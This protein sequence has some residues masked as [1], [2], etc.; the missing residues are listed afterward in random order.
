MIQN[1][2]KKVKKV[3]SNK[4]FLFIFTIVFILGLLL[5]VFKARAGLFDDIAN[6][7]NAALNAIEEEVG[8]LMKVMIEIF[9]T[10]CIGLVAVFTSS[11]ILQGLVA[12]TEWLKINTS[13]LVQSGWH[14]TAGLANLVLI[15]I[16]IIIAIGYILRLETLQARKSLIRL[17][18]VALLMNFSLV[19][20]GMLVDIAN[21]LYR[22][23]LEKGGPNFIVNV[24][25]QLT[26]GG[27]VLVIATVAFL[28]AT[29]VLWAIPVTA[30]FAQL[31][32]AIFMLTANLPTVIVWTFQIVIFFFMAGI[33][34]TYIFLFAARVF[35]IQILA[36]VSPLAFICLILPQTRK[37]FNEWLHH[38]L[39]WL[40]LGIMVLL[41]LVI[42]SKITAELSPP[43]LLTFVPVIGFFT[44][45]PTFSFY[46]FILIFL[47]MVLWLSK[48]TMPAMA[49]FIIQQ[50]TNMAGMAWQRVGAP[51][52]RG[53]KEQV[54]KTAAEQKG[55]EA[56]A[57]RR[58]E[59]GETLSR[60]ESFALKAGAVVAA[61]IR[62]TYRLRGTTPEAEMRKD[63]SKQASEFAAR[64]KEDRE[65]LIAYLPKLTPENQIAA[66]LALKELKGDKA[67]SKIP[68]DS[69]AGVIK[70]ASRLHPK[71]LD[72]LLTEVQRERAEKIAERDKSLA[73]ALKNWPEPEDMAAVIKD[74]TI[75]EGKEAS[76]LW[77]GSEADREKV[78]K[79]AR[80]RKA[81][82]N[83]K[84]EDYE[85]IT[86][87]MAAEEEFL[88]GAAR[89]CRSREAV[90]R[91]LE[92]GILD[93]GR[94]STTVQKLGIKE[95]AKTN[96]TVLTFPY[97]PGGHALGLA[98]YSNLRDQ[99]GRTITTDKTATEEIRRLT[100][101]IR[102]VAL[103]HERARDIVRGAPIGIPPSPTPP[104]SGRPGPGPT[105]GRPPRRPAG[106]P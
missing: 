9:L 71:K 103:S 59:R 28:I 56:E 26:G 3:L 61:P 106:R 58:L 19:F 68:D 30:P 15:I 35:V 72:D 25:A 83:L 4:K 76:E 96:T 23:I 78:R 57:K 87:E 86:P 89:Y 20:I 69:F 82:A 92:K 34:L 65:G 1:I 44:L 16:F 45:A 53:F 98:T 24:T 67:L 42:G 85:N 32:F 97:T 73:T 6:W 11:S 75:I 37:Y 31:G 62:W 104:P 43:N 70:S 13:T 22:T 14:F 33:F 93:W 101:E 74:R 81:F 52:T 84:V 7:A 90:R 77:K 21:I 105:P 29:V 5:P 95:V 27:L 60:G 50:A 39:G 8:P 88:E 46:F 17:I 91:M 38:L 63:I 55:K 2:F 18:V 10:Y 54:Q 99:Q 47:I 36:A 49:E 48:R 79:E 66:A 94:L 64:Y 100:Q 12:N 102:K 80:R 40:W 51:L 41:F